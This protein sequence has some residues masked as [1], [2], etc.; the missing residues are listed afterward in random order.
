M[1]AKCLHNPYTIKGPRS[2]VD[3]E[4]GAVSEDVMWAN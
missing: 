3:K 4:S 1:P 2:G